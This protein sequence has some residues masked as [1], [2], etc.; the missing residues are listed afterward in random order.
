M[1]VHPRPTGEVDDHP[2]GEDPG[3][4]QG[5]DHDLVGGHTH[6][7]GPGHD[8]TL[9]VPEVGHAHIPDHVLAPDKE[10]NG[11]F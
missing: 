8:L 6:V 4:V 5:H 11:Q 10:F 7:P 2:G 9:R 1:D 3:H